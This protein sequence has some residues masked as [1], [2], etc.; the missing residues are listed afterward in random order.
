MRTK[1][2]TTDGAA[3]LVLAVSA[4]AGRAQVE[5]GL[6][7]NPGFEQPSI[8][9]GAVAGAKPDRWFFFSSNEED[10]IGVTDRRKRGGM[11]SLKFQAQTATN[12]YAGMAQLFPAAPGYRYT[13]R[14]YVLGDAVDPI[15]DAAFGQI[16]LEWQDVSGKEIERVHGPLW[17]AAARADRWEPFVVE[18]EPP[19]GAVQGVAVVTFFSCD[20]LGRGTFYV[21]DAEISARAAQP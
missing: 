11:Q 3:L 8:I 21:D 16:S 13:F 1:R 7:K 18:G 15:G 10:K 6:L 12:Q 5:P 4:L 20:S 14:A 17:D 9:D 2:H 19:E